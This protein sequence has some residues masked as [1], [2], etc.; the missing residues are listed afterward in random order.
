MT[1]RKHHRWVLDESQISTYGLV[2]KQQ[3]EKLW[4]ENI[5]VHRRELNFLVFRDGS[6]LTTL[7]CEDLARADPCQA[8]IRAVGPNLLIALLMDGPQIKGRWSERYAMG[9]ADDPG[10]SVLSFTSLGLVTRSN[11]NQNEKSLAVGLWRDC[12]KGRTEILSLGHHEH[13][14]LLRLTKN[15]RE[16]TTLDG[17]KDGENA[18]VWKLDG[19]QGIC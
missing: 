9:L 1:Q 10:T 15:S 8:A 6:C 18:H 3:K 7:I 11:R 13:G 17:R 16:E 5:Q 19:Y 4:W 14:L 12:I 2:H